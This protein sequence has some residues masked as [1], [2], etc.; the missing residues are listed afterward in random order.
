MHHR[1]QLLTSEQRV[2]GT[3]SLLLINTLNIP[4]PPCSGPGALGFLICSNTSTNC[5]N[6]NLHDAAFP[7]RAPPRAPPTALLPKMHHPERGQDRT[8]VLLLLQLVGP[9][10]IS[11]IT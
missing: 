7:Y 3:A 11:R 6:F 2:T 9:R 8:R 5:C 4:I 1:V 10:C